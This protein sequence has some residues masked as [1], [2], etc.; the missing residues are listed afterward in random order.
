MNVF[1]LQDK[2]VTCTDATGGIGLEMSK[3]LGEAGADIASIQLPNVPNAASLSDQLKKIGR[4]IWVL[5]ATLRTPL[6]FALHFKRS[7]MP[8]STRLFSI[9]PVLT[10]EPQ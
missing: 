4:S 5:I 6:P 8:V 7:G 9:A 1:S 3:F 10:E 2:I